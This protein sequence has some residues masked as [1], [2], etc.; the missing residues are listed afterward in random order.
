MKKSNSPDQKIIATINIEEEMI[1]IDKIDSEKIKDHIENIA[2]KNNFVKK[3]TEIETIVRMKILIQGIN[4]QGNKMMIAMI[5]GE[6]EE[7]VTVRIIQLLKNQ[8]F[9]M[10]ELKILSLVIKR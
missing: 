10:T 7:V 9:Q 3:H 5:E 8:N 6:R 4:F 1:Q 2:T